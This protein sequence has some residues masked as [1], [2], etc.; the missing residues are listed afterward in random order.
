M[1]IFLK[2]NKKYFFSKNLVVTKKGFIFALGLGK[3]EVVFVL[4]LPPRQAILYSKMFF[5]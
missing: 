4:I 2:I 3:Y 1:Q 5:L